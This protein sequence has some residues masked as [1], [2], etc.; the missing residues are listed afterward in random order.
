MI[1]PGAAPAAHEACMAYPRSTFTLLSWIVL[2]HLCLL[3]LVLRVQAISL[4]GW[5]ALLGITA[6]GALILFGAVTA[7]RR[8]RGLSDRDYSLVVK[9]QHPPAHGREGHK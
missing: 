1:S 8:F 2:H 4:S 3:A 6:M 5:V 7:Y 9:Q